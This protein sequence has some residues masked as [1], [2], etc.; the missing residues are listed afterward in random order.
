M[1]VPNQKP[2]VSPA[3]AGT[4][5]TFILVFIDIAFAQIS[6]QRRVVLLPI[7]GKLFIIYEGADPEESRNK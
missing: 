5:P 1:E 3:I 2:I 4:V 7:H 6:A